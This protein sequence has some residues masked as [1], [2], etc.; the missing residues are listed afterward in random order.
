M[1]NQRIYNSSD[2]FIIRTPLFPIVMY[3]KI[4]DENEILLSEDRLID[5]VSNNDIIKEAI[6]VSSIPLYNEL[7]RKHGIKDY[8][9]K[10]KIISSLVKYL[11]RM[12]TR[13]T[14]FGLFAGVG[15]GSF[16]NSTE[17]NIMENKNNFKRTRP[18]MEWILGI[19]KNLEQEFSCLENLYLIKNKLAFQDGDRLEI[20]Y[21][22]NCGQTAK[23]NNSDNLI[24]SVRNTSQ[25]K[26]VLKM[27]EKPIRYK[28]LF[29]ILIEKN[30]DV[31]KEKI[32]NFLNELVSN[33]YLITELKPSLDTPDVFQCLIHKISLINSKEKLYNDLLEIEMLIR[34]YDKIPIGEGINK[35]LA[36]INKMERIH[37]CKN[38][39]QVDMLTNT[40]K[41]N[42]DN[43]IKIEVEKLGALLFKLSSNGSKYNYLQEYLDEFLEVYGEERE[44]QVLELLH[45]GK[46]LGAPF[47][48]TKPM[49]TK[50][51]E[52]DKEDIEESRLKNY[53]INKVLKCIRDNEEEVILSDEEIEEYSINYNTNE[54][55]QSIEIFTH[56]SKV[57]LDG[58]EDFRL[59]L[60][61]L[62][63]SRSYGKSFGRFMDMFPIK[64]RDYLINIEKEQNNL[65]D[66]DTIIA[67]INE[68]PQ[69]GRLS[70][71][72]LNLNACEYDLTISANDSKEKKS[73]NIDDL[74][75][76]VEIKNNKR[77][78]YIKSKSLNKKII[79]K[80]NNMLNIRL[81]SNVYRLLL[82]ISM[83]EEKDITS[84]LYTTFFTTFNNFNFV[85]R[86]I[87]SKSVLYPATWLI[88]SKNLGLDI[89]KCSKDEFYEAINLWIND[90][91]VPNYVYLKE[92]DNRLLLNL[93]NKLHL[94]EIY[95]LLKNNYK[96]IIITEIEGQLKN[97]ISLGKNEKYCSEF[98]IPIFKNKDL[99]EK[100]LD[101]KKKQTLITN[102]NF[103]NRRNEI[104]SLDSE[105]VFLPGDEWLSVKIYCSIDRIEE[106]ISFYLLPFSET[107]INEGDADKFFFLRYADP[108]FHIR[109]RIK[110]TKVNIQQKV[111]P[112]INTFFKE[113]L[114]R[115][116]SNNIIIDSYKREIERYGGPQLIELAEDIFYDDSK[117][118]KELLNIGDLNLDSFLIV[119]IINILTE[120]GLN[121]KDQKEM[122]CS[123]YD[124]STNREM[125]QKNRKK[126][127]N[128]CNSY[129]N[130]ENL[131]Q[132]QKGLKLFQLFQLRKK[133]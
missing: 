9:N 56:I 64:M 35:Y 114:D 5:F 125:F 2:I 128:I 113:L 28:E 108:Q 82:E 53:L 31:S 33:E 36:I 61:P 24:A 107:L 60:S 46:G 115:G 62:W 48:Y 16:S 51:R 92:S 57:N 109:L 85:P 72:S 66:K 6:L 69:V 54:I 126:L 81:C 86:I 80:A 124:K 121:F 93:K 77:K 105:R 74:Y 112:K 87:Y 94:N 118:T 4:F 104:S 68:L 50:K 111:I 103:L 15:T 96:N 43:K 11:I 18:D 119:S 99:I 129:N 98:V 20:S 27:A 26:K 45:E 34:E 39:L 89:T 97:K 70:N 14:P 42:L 55:P 71:V 17:I 37:K 58:N 123:I 133:I 122:F 91:K 102:S 79:F 1:L 131:R 49:S 120:L 32:S 100:D 116:L 65:C 127:L 95:L 40:K 38:Y 7:K 19:I 59:Y 106:L 13:A 76:G 132:T 23:E 8:K 110:G 25:V 10:E 84:I 22:S 29:K 30:P 83:M 117:I 21:L 75:I 63:G 101:L 52:Y 67:N 78:F 73:I 3:T 130:W 12:T 90:Y 88:N 44:I 41:V 47:G